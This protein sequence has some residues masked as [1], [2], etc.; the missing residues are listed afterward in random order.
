MVLDHDSLQEAP[1]PEPVSFSVKN[2]VYRAHGGQVFLSSALRMYS[3]N[4]Q[5]L[6]DGFEALFR[7][8]KL[9]D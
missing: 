3:Q 9:S 8:P 5:F 4:F 2:S 6:E 1:C 7:R